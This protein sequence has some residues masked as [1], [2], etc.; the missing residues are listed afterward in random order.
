MSWNF[1]AVWRPGTGAQHWET[2]MSFDRLK[3]VDDVLFNNKGLRLVVLRQ[4]T[5][6]E[7]SAVWRSGT[8]EQHWSAGIDADEFKQRDT[9]F[10]NKG[11]RLAAMHVLGD[12][13][14]AVWRPGSGEQ[15]WH[16]GI[17]FDQFKQ[18]DSKLFNKG[19]RLLT[20][21]RDYNGGFDEF[22]GVWRADL[23]TGGQHWWT[24]KGTAFET[25]KTENEKQVQ[26]GRRLVAFP[27]YALNA[28]WRDG[29]GKQE[30]LNDGTAST[31]EKTDK[32]LFNQGMRLVDLML[33]ESI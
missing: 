11:L 1:F 26:A 15:H 14:S 23:G 21:M 12:R 10:F 18:T 24:D 17:N 25:F 16:V 19:L 31:M 13:F 22:M 7:F 20:M 6:D 4:D 5:D 2:G 33:G 9:H 30:L 8:G 28:I 3:H 27:P 29:S 32:E